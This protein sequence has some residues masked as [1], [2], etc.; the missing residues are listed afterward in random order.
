MAFYRGDDLP[1]IEINLENNTGQTITKAEVVF[2][3]GTI[4]KSFTNPIFPISVTL[5]A[6]ESKNLAIGLNV[7][8]LI[9]Y[10][11]DKKRTCDGALRFD[12][13]REVYIAS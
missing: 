9:V 3:G 6:T 8:N 2:N 4:V 11:D 1:P 10:V 7:C 13:E 5:D 12:L